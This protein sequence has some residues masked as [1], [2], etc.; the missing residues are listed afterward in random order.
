MKAIVEEVDYHGVSVTVHRDRNSNA[1]QYE[2]IME[3]VDKNLRN[4]KGDFLRKLDLVV[5]SDDQI[6]LSGVYSSRA[7]NRIK[8]GGK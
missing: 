4:D 5:D 3:I 6:E 8:K 7:I 1:L 2:E